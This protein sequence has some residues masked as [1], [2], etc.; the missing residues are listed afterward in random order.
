MTRRRESRVMRW[1]RDRMEP[2]MIV[3][4]EVGISVVNVT[5]VAHEE[6]GRLR[7]RLRDL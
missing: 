6:C 2:V 4:C 5:A 3:L 7:E 1:V